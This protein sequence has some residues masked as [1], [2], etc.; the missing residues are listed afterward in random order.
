M[1]IEEAIAW[2]E[3]K[4]SSVN[5]IPDYPHETWPIRI[6]EADAWYTQQAYWIA[7]AHG[8]LPR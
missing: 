1:S 8:A 2:L 4:R 3:G 6:A 7:K 5:M